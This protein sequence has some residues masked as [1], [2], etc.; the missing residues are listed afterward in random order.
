M[1]ETYQGTVVLLDNA[2]LG[3][4]KRLTAMAVG[5]VKTLAGDARLGVVLHHAVKGEGALV[6]EDAGEDIACF[7]AGVVIVDCVKSQGMPLS[8]RSLTSPVTK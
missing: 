5:P 1:D 7:V 6:V 4:K 8:M 3:R 2:D